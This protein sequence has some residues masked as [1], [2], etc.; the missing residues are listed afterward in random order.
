MPL[1][2]EYST[3]RQKLVCF[4]DYGWGKAAEGERKR[5]AHTLHFINLAAKIFSFLLLR[6]LL[7]K[8][9]NVRD[10]M[11]MRCRVKEDLLGD[12]II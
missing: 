3:T 2:K 12:E 7:D 5:L 8:H 11:E 6:H 4:D 10:R 9:R 1:I